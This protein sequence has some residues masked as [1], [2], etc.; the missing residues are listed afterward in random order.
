MPLYPVKNLKTGEVKDIHMPVA[1]YEQW[2]IDNPDWDK[3]WS[4]GCAGL[5][6]R[7]ASYYN[8]DNLASGTNYED[9]N[10]SLAENA[11]ED[12]KS[13]MSE[14][15]ASNNANIKSKLRIN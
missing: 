6:T 12:T 7:D 3:D 5:R 11:P 9:K 8:V 15:M 1:Q 14:K 13:S 2:R 10:C 4:Q